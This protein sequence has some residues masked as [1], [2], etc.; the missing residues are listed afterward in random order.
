MLAAVLIEDGQYDQA[1][2]HL[3]ESLILREIAAAQEP[4]T[5]RP[6]E[7]KLV[8]DTEATIGKNNQSA[9]HD[10]SHSSLE[11]TRALLKR[12]LAGK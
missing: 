2:A 8:S 1:E 11:R 3:R 4:S 7:N 10:N 12:A 6:L 9:A 5:V